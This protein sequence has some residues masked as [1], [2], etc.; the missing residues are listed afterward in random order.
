MILNIYFGSQSRFGNEPGPLPELLLPL[1]C[2]C[3]ICLTQLNRKMRKKKKKR[4]TN[5]S[6]K[7]TEYIHVVVVV[8]S[9]IS[10]NY[11]AVLWRQTR[12]ATQML[13]HAR[14]S[15]PF[16]IFLYSLIFYPN[17]FHFYFISLFIFHLIWFN[18]TGK[19]LY[20]ASIR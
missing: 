16:Y 13:A 8:I 3:I 18:M 7:Y 11:Y 17:L 14:H 19:C 5:G 2:A 4:I 12:R 9:S 10:K 20:Y 6:I 15:S 1:G